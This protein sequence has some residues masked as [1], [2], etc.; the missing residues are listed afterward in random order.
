MRADREIHLAVGLV[1]DCAR[2]AECVPADGI[3]YQQLKLERIALPRL[4]A[5]C[6][7]EGHGISALL[8]ESKHRVAREA[9]LR[10][11]IFAAAV[12]VFPVQELTDY[13]EKNWRS[14]VPD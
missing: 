6:E 4:V 14:A 5:R 7:G 3:F 9:V 13:R 12:A 11:L 8:F 10:H 2:A 1:Y